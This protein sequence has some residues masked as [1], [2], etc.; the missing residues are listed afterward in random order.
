MEKGRLRKILIGAAV[1]AGLMAAGGTSLGAP[2]QQDLGAIRIGSLTTLETPTAANTF[3]GASTIHTIGLQFAN[4]TSFTRPVEIIELSR[5]LR[6][7]PDLIYEYVRNNIEI[8]PL[9]GLQ[10]GALGALI[11]K[12][13]TAFDQVHL[14][15]ELLRE[16]GHV[17]SYKVGAITLNQQAFSEWFGITNARAAC[18]LLASSGF[19]GT[20]NGLTACT[21]LSGNITSVT[22]THIWAEVN[23]GGTNYLFDPS[24]KPHTFKTTINLETAMS[25]SRTDLH[26]AFSSGMTSGKT[27]GISFITGLNE[28]GL[29][30]KLDTY[31]GNLLTNLQSVHPD[32]ALEDIVGGRELVP[33]VLP[34][35]GLRQTSL[36][37][38]TTVFHTWSG[39]TDIPDQYRTRLSIRLDHANVL[40][41]KTAVFFVDEAGGRRIDLM[42]D[43]SAADWKS[44]NFQVFDT[45]GF[46]VAIQVDGKTVKQPDGT[47][48]EFSSTQPAPLRSGFDLEF[49]IEHP[50]AAQSGDY[51]D[52]VIK[53]RADIFMPVA[54]IHGWG[55]VSQELFNAWAKENSSDGR[56][57]Y[58]NS[59]DSGGEPILIFTSTQDSLKTKLAAGWMTSYTRMTEMVGGMTDTTSV[60]H[61]AIGP[62]FMQAFIGTENACAG[63]VAAQW[64]QDQYI[65]M[66]IDSAISVTH[67]TADALKR[68]AAIHTI[69]AAANTLEGTMVEQMIDEPDAASTAERF[70]WAEEWPD[71]NAQFPGSNVE[72]SSAVRFYKFKPTAKFADVLDI[73]KKQGFAHN[74]INASTVPQHLQ[75]V[76]TT[77]S[78]IKQYLDAGHYVVA[79]D[80]SFLGPGAHKSPPVQ[81]ANCAPP[82]Q[83]SCFRSTL[84][85]GGAFIA[86]K[87]DGT[88]VAHVVDHWTDTFKGGG[89]GVSKDQ[90]D[91]FDPST[92]ADVLKDRFENKSVVHGI[93]LADGGYSFTTPT[94]LSV[95]SGGFPY[96]LSVGL[97]F[98]SGALAPSPT[99]D[100]G[101]LVTHSFESQLSLSGS[102]AEALGASSHLNAAA[103]IVALYAA[104]D[105]Y[106]ADEDALFN[107]VLLPFINEW[108]AESMKLNVVS[109]SV[110]ASNVQFVQLADGNYNPP[111]GDPSKLV[112]LAGTRT[113]TTLAPD[114]FDNYYVHADWRFALTLPDQSI[115]TFQ[116]R[117]IN[118][119]SGGPVSP[120]VNRLESWDF[121]FGVTVT[122]TYDS[123]PANFA[124]LKSVSNNVGRTILINR[125][126]QGAVTGFS[127]LTGRTV[128]LTKNLID[129][130]I[131]TPAGDVMRVDIENSNPATDARFF[132]GYRFVSQI[133]EPWAY[134]AG[135]QTFSQASLNY[136][137]DA[138]WR[139]REVEDAQ[140]IADLAAGAPS[141]RPSHQFFIANGGR[142]ERTDP[143]G[144]EFAVYYDL[145]GRA[146][147]FIDEL[148]RPITAEH[149][150]HNR[151]T[152]R[153][154]PEGNESI[155]AYDTNHQ[156]TGFTQRAKSGSGLADRSASAVYHGTYF[157][158]PTNVTDTLG[159][160]TNIAYDALTGNV[161][162]ATLPDLE[163]YSSTHNAFGQVVTVTDPESR[164]T[165]NS[166]ST[167]ATGSN[168]LSTKIDNLGLGLTKYFEYDLVGNAVA[169]RDP[170]SSSSLDNTYRTQI[171]FDLDRRE[172]ETID[173][174]GNKSR[175]TYTGG[176]LTKVEALDFLGVVLQTTLMSHTPTGQELSVTSPDGAVTTKAYDAV[177]RL[178]TV[179]D[180]VG[181]VTKSVYD[182]A[183]Q[184]LIE[185]RAF[186][187]PLQQDY[188]TFTY[189]L[190]GLQADVTDANG[191]K[192]IFTYDGFD[193]LGTSTFP[194]LTTEVFTY[195]AANNVLKK[196]TRKGDYIASAYD[197]RGRQVRKL[198]S[199][200][201]PGIITTTCGA[202]AFDTCFA[203]DGVGRQTQARFGDGGYVID[204]VYD[205]AGRL[206]D[207]TNSGTKVAG[208]ARTVAYQLDAATN[209]IRITHP[210]GLFVDQ[211]FDVR[212]LMTDLKLSGPITVES[213]T[214]DAL[215]RR[216]LRSIEG[217]VSAVS[218]AYEADSALDALDID[219][220]GTA[221]DVIYSFDYT[222][223]NQM[224]LKDITNVAYEYDGT[225]TP[226]TSYTVN[227][228]NQYP[229]L[230]QAG[231]PITLSYD[232]NGNLLSDGSWSYTYD[233][234]NRL[235]TATSATNTAMIE[236]DPLGRL[237]ATL[238]DGTRRE[239]LYNGV[240]L[241]ALYDGSGAIAER[242]TWGPGVDE[243]LVWYF[244]GTTAG[245][246]HLV[247]DHQGS[248]LRRVSNIGG[249]SADIQVY[250]E[251]GVP[252]AISG[253]GFKY[254]GQ[255]Y[256][257]T[258]GLYYYKAR[259]YA[260][261][262][263]RFLQTDPI[264][265]EDNLNL[266][267]YVGNDPVNAIDPNG[268]DTFLVTRAFLN[269]KATQAV[270]TALVVRNEQGTQVISFTR[271]DGLLT[272]TVEGDK[273][274]DDDLTQFRESLRDGNT[275]EGTGSVTRL[276]GD[277]NFD[278]AILDAADRVLDGQPY[279]LTPDDDP[280]DGVNSNSAS[281][282]I[283]DEAQRQTGSLNEAKINALFRQ[284]SPSAKG[285]DQ[286]G[287]VK[288]EPKKGGA[289]KT[290]TAA[291]TGKGC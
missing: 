273:T 181:R 221:N 42:P 119:G 111:K 137:V 47:I 19:P 78:H 220:A 237:S 36:S 211:T 15:V 61:H 199:L 26:N 20:V 258:L 51:M 100:L 173:P 175:N 250:D 122:Y 86:F 191:N 72:R 215:A 285:L 233:I 169:V 107:M 2:T 97:T 10:K 32:D 130:D 80:D 79:V 66:N 153:V 43:K 62:V 90:E 288:F 186:G 170:R 68:K 54:I 48:A 104:Y 149:D 189:T 174:L 254:T 193:R 232:L 158:K 46:H 34:A 45:T 127:D 109:A 151:V 185:Q 121:P 154:F 64:V 289:C 93:S 71:T 94:L 136:I 52:E 13:G 164:V 65:R 110:G 163:V 245:R 116:Q 23:I 197:V 99:E 269:I 166:Y 223:A 219:L 162:T 195:D 265:Y 58:V 287:R 59:A 12:H 9:F 8:T 17:A 268:Q 40:A 3:Y 281:G 75:W 35:G 53:K 139:A 242:W 102:A 275:E 56:R 200:A 177:D 278:A 284:I 247:A 140:R 55:R 202:T 105:A 67:N 33:E 168:L 88:S 198:L 276:S 22:M 252:Q 117:D 208:G 7:D 261:T 30:T 118:D 14:M 6:G 85:R 142:G 73:I 126:V 84:Q 155:F 274:F 148:G 206:K 21:S 115:Q 179:T 144:G 159:N 129:W 231:T 176:R 256:E 178:L 183:G 243:P 5:A 184:L 44:Q 204:N 249:G 87:T 18:E 246:R 152:R 259:W 253:Q 160:V 69:A 212:S 108:W 112:R 57:F 263:G 207:V 201:D 131:T 222:L 83:N 172:L 92:A 76:A 244:D 103:S 209:V 171:T 31:A 190:N 266:Y 238:I 70:R 157:T 113:I 213:F 272:R 74:D 91:E 16:A 270:H 167:A 248:I 260:P 267:A 224:S 187:S 82:A 165:L 156:L 283:V 257:S 227:N 228:L 280:P 125:D 251:W 41:P 11:D 234:E 240:E 182:P 235:V 133:F 37:Y 123:L 271:E 141:P 101:N 39:T 50:Y 192:T 196:K 277:P 29:D 27:K 229:S 1:S 138:L 98:S 264:G 95:G 279:D 28:A 49:T 96:E 128:S 210:D 143:G 24:K 282:A 217:G 25:Y 77:A 218:F 216:T 150:N 241:L 180:P 262:L 286:R 290:Q 145:K 63:C 226:D 225:G 38:V 106:L 135:T 161:L 132:E 124:D 120:H 60:Q 239:R 203:Y 81:T 146:V 255:F 4:G 188:A 114:F 230:N 89:G 205:T 236:Y 134:D 214:Y 291:K 147:E 194:D